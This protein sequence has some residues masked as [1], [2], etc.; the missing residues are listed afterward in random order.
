MNFNKRVKI[1][2]TANSP[3]M[4][5]YTQGLMTQAMREFLSAPNPLPEDTLV[6]DF[7]YLD[8]DGMVHTLNPHQIVRERVRKHPAPLGSPVYK[9]T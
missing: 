4:D 6:F 7:S 3:M 9:K 1:Q 8:E 2:L 5:T